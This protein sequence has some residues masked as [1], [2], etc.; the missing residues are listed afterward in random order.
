[1]CSSDLGRVIVAAISGEQRSPLMPDV[2]TFNESGYPEFGNDG[3]YGLVV[4]G[5]TPKAVMERIAADVARTLGAPD[6]VRSLDAQGAAPKWAGPD[7]FQAL[8]RVEVERIGKV[9]RAAGARAD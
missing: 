9:I 7:A 6:I 8:I 4:Q 5:R 2:P 1:M 3:W